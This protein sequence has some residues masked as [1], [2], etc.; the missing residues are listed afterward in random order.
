MGRPEP[1]AQVEVS[2]AL[3]RNVHKWMGNR[4]CDPKDGVDDLLRNELTHAQGSPDTRTRQEW[5]QQ[6]LVPFLELL[7]ADFEGHRLLS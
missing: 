4:P 7:Q 3:H 1:S 6:K 5:R 2:G